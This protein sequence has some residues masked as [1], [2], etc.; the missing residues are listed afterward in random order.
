[1]PLL[2]TLVGVIL[3]NAYSTMQRQTSPHTG[4]G[5][6]RWHGVNRP[7]ADFSPHWWG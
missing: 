4:G 1:M 7:K 6:P 3:R 5:N 2:P